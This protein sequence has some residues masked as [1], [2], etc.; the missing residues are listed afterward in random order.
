MEPANT[1]DRAESLFSRALELP[2]SER[3]GFVQAECANDPLLGQ[4]VLRLLEAE[5]L[6]GSF[7]DA[8]AMDFRSEEFGAYRADEEIGRGGMSVVYEGHRVDGDFDRKVAIKVVLSHVGGAPE[9]RMLSALEHPNVA[10]LYDAGVTSLGFRYLV[11]ELVEGVPCTQFAGAREQK[12]KLAL[13]LQ[14]CAGVQA[15][16]Q[17]LIVHRDLKPSNALVTDEG[18]VK[19]LD[20]GI[21]KMLTPT[22]DQTAGPRA[23]TPDYASPEQIEGRPASIA[24]DVYSLGI[25]L[26]ELLT[27]TRPAPDASLPAALQGDLRLIV[28]KA[29]HRDP[30]LRYESVRAMA[31]DVERYL[32]GLPISARPASLSYLAGRY[33]ARHRV[34]VLA[35]A[36]VLLGVA[37]L[38]LYSAWQARLANQRY[39]QVRSLSKAVIFDLLDAVRP[40]SGAEKA[41]KLIVERSQSYL[42][43]VA[44]NPN[45]DDSALIEAARGYMRLA[46]SDPASGSELKARAA[47]I[48]RKVLVRTP[49]HREAQELL[50]SATQ[51]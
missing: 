5:S 48:C 35:G 25:L 42:D 7:L 44:G 47:A 13:F 18:G 15:A 36:L 45:A 37:G 46:A 22:G 4:E 10:R 12:D 32:E 6:M 24:N 11:M 20:F 9:T 39:E 50:G 29:V 27:V 38:G 19:I 41:Q 33:F 17:A 30:A 14:I 16:H 49:A 2:A 21:A 3:E 51:H 1:W 28:G 34:A 40:L 26:C 43:G 8:P 31:N 23:F